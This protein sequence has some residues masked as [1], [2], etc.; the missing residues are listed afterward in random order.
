MPVRFSSSDLIKKIEA[1]GWF[2]VRVKGSHHHFKH[3]TKTGIVT[4][5]HPEKATPQGTA[6]NIL[7]QAGLK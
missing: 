3:P 6:N 4:I 5:K 1:D 2:L 7:R